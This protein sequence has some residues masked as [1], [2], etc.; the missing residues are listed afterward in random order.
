MLFK[1]NFCKVKLKQKLDI[2]TKHHPN[3]I[4][5]SARFQPAFIEG[6]LK[7]SKHPA[8]I[9]IYYIQG[10]PKCSEHHICVCIYIHGKPKSFEH[11][12]CLYIKIQGK[13]KSSEHPTRICVYIY[14]VS[15]KAPS[16]LLVSCI[17]KW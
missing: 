10:K 15:H 2:K 14:M 3:A 7:I 8:C 9:Y 4:L 16:T 6:K 5:F 11:R 12:I 17:F 1:L 13:L